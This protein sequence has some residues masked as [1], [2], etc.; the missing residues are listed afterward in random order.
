MT[1]IKSGLP[2]TSAALVEV[3][4]TS[5][6]EEGIQERS[7][8]QA[9][10]RDHIDLIDHDL[11]VIAEEFGDFEGANRRIDLLCIDKNCKLVVVELKRTVDGGGT[12]SS[13]PS[14]TRR[15]SRP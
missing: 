7:H 2:S 5:F 15:W 1:A 3:T 4:R 13:K 10:L 8:L 12:W 6:A 11:H 9:A 14:V